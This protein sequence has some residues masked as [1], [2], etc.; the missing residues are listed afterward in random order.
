MD[1]SLVVLAIVTCGSYVVLS[2]VSP[3]IAAEGLDESWSMLTQSVPWIVVS[4]FAAGL[5]AQLIEPSS[6]ARWFGP[7]S[8]LF[9]IVLAALLGLFGTGSRWAVYPIAAGLLSADAT[10]G[11]VFAFITSWQLVSLTRLPAEVPFFGVRYTVIRTV[12]SVLIAIAG[13]VLFNIAW[14]QF[15]SPDE[16]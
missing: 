3:H 12:I 11:A 14:Q 10:P 9:G 5:A 15:K 1:K 7:K 4:M 8:G 16:M 6:I 13:G 2:F